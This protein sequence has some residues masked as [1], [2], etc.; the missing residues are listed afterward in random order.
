MALNP[1]KTFL[2]PEL[3]KGLLVTARTFVTNK[4]TLNYPEE[5]TPQSPRFRGLHALRRY[6]NGQERCIA[7]KLCE[8]VCP[9]VCIT[10]DSDVAP[11]GTRRTTRYDIDPSSASIAASARKPARWM[12][13]CS[14]AFTSTTWKGAVRTS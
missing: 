4:Y 5:K 11:D 13:S 12:R 3:I 14:P 10:I 9:A 1:L 2:M 8:A 6:P 7:C